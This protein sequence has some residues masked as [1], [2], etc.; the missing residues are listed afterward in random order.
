MQKY[1]KNNNIILLVI[2]FEF[3]KIVAII[4]VKN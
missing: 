3:F 1:I 2:N 4:I